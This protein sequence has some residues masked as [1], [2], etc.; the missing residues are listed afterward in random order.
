MG[1]QEHKV[2]R[3]LVAIFAADVAGYSRLMAQDEVGTLRSLTACREIMDRLITEHGGRIA[4]TAGDSVLAEFP[5]AVDAVQCAV[6]VQDR[7]AS[8]PTAPRLQFRIGV[9]V[10]DVMIRS[11]DLLGD[12]VNIAARLQGLAEPG[13][14]CISGATHDYVR[15]ALSLSFT[16]LGLQAVK[17][18]EEPIRA[19]AWRAA[20]AGEPMAHDRARLLSGKPFVAVLPF[21]NLSGD[22]EHLYFAEGLREDIIA[23]LL[24]FSGM[25]VISNYS[26]SGQRQAKHSVQDRDAPYILE[27]SV[28]RAGNRVRVN[29]QLTS[30]SGES[31]WAEKYDVELEDVFAVQDELARNI[32]AALRIK[33]EE[34]ERR[35]ALTKPPT[36]LTAYD[37]CLRGRRLERNFDRSQR[38]HARTLFRSAIEADPEYSRG[39]IG[40]AW[41]ELRTLKW[42]EPSDRDA[43]LARALDAASKATELEP[44]DAECHWA[45]G[46]AHLWKRDPD[47]AIAS[48]EKAR[49]L[50]PNHADLLSDLCDTLTYL[51]KFEEAIQ[52]GKTALRLNPNPPD[53]HLWNVA[54][55]YYLSGDYDM[56]LNYLQQMAQPGPAYRLIAA[57]H[58]QLGHLEKARQAAA[59]LLKINPDFSISRFAAQAPYINAED[60]ARYVT[61]LRLAG[62]PE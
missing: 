55:G 14:I 4:N 56:A 40:L 47:K 50:C 35:L 10:G 30:P 48:Y 27:G 32:P 6:A 59:E 39:Y 22:H 45:L 8:D 28:R 15:K 25:V 53:W 9:H 24:R 46:L 31:L 60:L 11:S 20:S 51:G 52:I 23:S 57:T 44:N 18:I 61:G 49:T 41:F 21:V 43:T 3:R 29:T 33:L 1:P 16:D 13:G 26:L 38:A 34:H 12:G 54:A 17:N 19:Y 58:A 7:L 62:L 2:E 37:Y 5:S 36:N 42:G